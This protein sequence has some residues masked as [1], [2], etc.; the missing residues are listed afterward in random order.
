MFT[1][2]LTDAGTRNSFLDT[3]HRSFNGLNG[4]WYGSQQ[5]ATV[6]N[7]YRVGIGLGNERGLQERY[8]TDYGYRWTMG[9]SDATAGEQFY[10]ILDE[11]NGVNRLS[12]GQ[13]NHGQS[14]TNNQTVIN[15]AGT[16]AVVLN[17]SNGA[18]TGGT[19]FGSGGAS[20]TTVATIDHAGNAQ[21]NGT[22][23]TGGTSQSTGTMTVRNNS[24]A[25]VDYYLWPGLTTS[26]KGS[27]TYKDWNGNSQWYMVKDASNNWALNSAIGGLDSFKAYQST[28]SGDTYVGASSPTGVVRVNYETGA[29]AGFNIYGGS[30]S[31]LYASFTGTAAIKFPGL[32][33]G[34]GHSCL[35]I[36][37][38]G[39]IT[40][41]G[42]SCGTGSGG[43]SGTVGSATTGQIAYYTGNG[44]TIGGVSLVPVSAGG[45]GAS[46]AAGALASIGAQASIAGLGSD[47]ASGILVT[48]NVT[49]NTSSSSTI[50]GAIDAM[51]FPGADP[52]I[53]M[54]NALATVLA[55]GAHVLARAVETSN[56]PQTC[57]VDPF[58]TILTT[59]TSGVLEIDQAWLSLAVGWQVPNSWIVEGSG[60]GTVLQASAGF[61]GT[62]LITLGKQNSD[63]GPAANR[64]GVRLENV[65]VD[66]NNNTNIA[67]CIYTNTIQEQSG[68]DH[69]MVQNFMNTGIK[70]D[71][72]ATATPQNWHM[73]DV[74]VYPAACTGTCTAP[75]P[76]DID[77]NGGASGSHDLHGFTLTGNGRSGA[78]GIRVN[79][80]EGME[81]SS[82]HCENLADCFDIGDLFG[83][84]GLTVSGVSG[85]SAVTNLIHIHSTAG[86][87][88]RG[89]VFSGLAPLGAVT[90]ILDDMTGYSTAN[91]I[92]IY[93]TASDVGL[94]T[95]GA[96]AQTI[97]DLVLVPANNGTGNSA[98][99]H[100]TLESKY[101]NGAT[102]NNIASL[103]QNLV[104]GP[105]TAPT[106]SV[107]TIGY[108]GPGN[109]QM[110]LPAG[111][112]EK[113]WTVQSGNLSSALS[114]GFAQLAHTDTVAWQNNA[115]TGVDTLAPCSG[116]DTLC[117]SGAPVAAQSSVV[118]EQMFVSECYGGTFPTSASTLI[119]TRSGALTTTCA[120]TSYTVSLSNLMGVAGTAKKLLVRVG[121]AGNTSTDGCTM[122]LNSVAQSMTAI[123]GTTLT[124]ASDT[125]HT[126]NFN[127]GDMVEAR[128]GV[129]ANDSQLQWIAATF[130]VSWSPI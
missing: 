80:T 31:S 33:A 67:N 1:G 122:Y 46:T 128:C 76:V 62:F 107:W 100:A 24:D 68:L 37:T 43:G 32:A 92:P 52:C 94:P 44:T 14:G 56:V 73:W 21:F 9:L 120:Q 71:N 27:Y 95:F 22:L 114:S 59:N 74:E 49:A 54:A 42:T 5:D 53:K 63:T 105:G 88:E 98:S 82:V 106:Y 103:A 119:L 118:S 111:T 86:Q 90:T 3:F 129:G 58:A 101:Y 61:T 47:G 6:T 55:H 124:T 127:A 125:T 69:V 93:T 8:Q 35:Q 126:F 78:V 29:G 109:L 10:Q 104:P 15:S 25:E 12:I 97:G 113:V 16:G 48:G 38:S 28:N 51:A 81:I 64:F 99:P 130:V 26:Q 19:I 121:A 4:D 17:G 85:N 89:L 36:D 116:A 57:S 13:Y 79:N 39:Y 87:V 115:G 96:G 7:H 72:T 60:R 23:L 77:V 45:T 84:Y 18:G 83:N 108:T 40:N 75:A 34:T 117:W 110:Q 91:P 11:L 50:D 70:I 30:S 41:T 65:A 123:T 2:K 66:C 20:E 112:V 102:Y